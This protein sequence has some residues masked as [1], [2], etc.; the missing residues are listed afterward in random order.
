MNQHRVTPKM[1]RPFKRAVGIIL[2]RSDKD[3]N[4]ISGKK[5]EVGRLG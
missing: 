4:S 5:N 2:I 3:L 1:G